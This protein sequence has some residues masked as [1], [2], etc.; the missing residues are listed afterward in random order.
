MRGFQHA[1]TAVAVI[2]FASVAF[3]ADMPVKAPPLAPP[4]VITT[5]W[6]GFYLDGDIGWEQS[7][8]NWSWPTPIVGL[9]FGPPFSMSQ[10]GGVMGGHIGYQQQ[11]GWLVVGGEWGG[12]ALMN[13]KW[14]S[15][16]ETAPLGP[17]G[18]CGFPILGVGQQCQAQ[19]GPVMTAGGKLG[20]DWGN[21]LVYGVGGAAWGSVSSQIVPA[22][23]VAIGDAANPLGL[24][25][26]YYAGG[27]LDYMFASTRLF[28]FIAG[29]EYEHV[30]LGSHLQLSSLPLPVPFTVGNSIN[31]TVS[32]TEDI[33]WGKLTVKFNP[34]R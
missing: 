26:G 18:V 9:G 1:V 16:T 6:T 7:H 31:R 24:S 19:I 17:L 23:G 34:W 10:S 28:D 4:P 2:A 27:G 21:W 30:D 15:V 3:A 11:F 12:S 5:N 8:Y 13:S 29:V 22:P 20:V 33:V 25:H 32:A 14:A